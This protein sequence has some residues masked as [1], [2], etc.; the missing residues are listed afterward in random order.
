MTVDKYISPLYYKFLLD[1]NTLCKVYNPA[2]LLDIIFL[3]F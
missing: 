3:L 2:L 1:Q